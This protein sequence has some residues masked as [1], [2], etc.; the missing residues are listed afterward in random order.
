MLWQVENYIPPEYCYSRR[1]WSRGDGGP[2]L[3]SPSPATL[4]PAPGSREGRAGL[5]LM[6]SVRCIIG[7]V[8][9]GEWRFIPVPPG[10]FGVTV[11]FSSWRLGLRPE[12]LLISPT[13]IKP[14]PIDL[15]PSWLSDHKFGIPL[16]S[17]REKKCSLQ[18]CPIV[19]NNLI[20]H[21]FIK[22][23]F[24]FKKLNPLPP[25]WRSSLYLLP[26]SV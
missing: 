5:P 12:R 13:D 7:V 26:I 19:S 6:V 2:G 24:P 16:H 14:T 15:S 8:R 1:P 20:P 22:W 10:Y 3:H 11:V 4:V 25:Q 23:F 17:F 9:W 21:K 18:S